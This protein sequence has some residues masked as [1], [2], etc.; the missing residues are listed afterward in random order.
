MW[1]N[2]SEW[3]PSYLHT[4]NTLVLYAQTATNLDMHADLYFGYTWKVSSERNYVQVTCLECDLGMAVH[5]GFV[6]FLQYTMRRLPRM[7]QIGFQRSC[8]SLQVREFCKLLCCTFLRNCCSKAHSLAG[9][10]QPSVLSLKGCMHQFT[11]A[12]ITHCISS[13]IGI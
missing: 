8:A 11:H 2:R 6:P 13:N 10:L 4:V 1:K 9:F 7:K 3:E 5:N 12:L